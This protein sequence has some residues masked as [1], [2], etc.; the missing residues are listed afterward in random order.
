MKPWKAWK[1]NGNWSQ[2]PICIIRFQPAVAVRVLLQDH[3]KQN[4]N[5]CSQSWHYHLTSCSH[6]CYSLE[7]QDIA[8]HKSA[9]PT[10]LKHV[11]LEFW[12]CI[13]W[14]FI[15]RLIS[16][17]WYWCFDLDMFVLCSRSCSLFWVIFVVDVFLFFHFGC[18]VFSCSLSGGNWHRS[19][20]HS[21]ALSSLTVQLSVPPIIVLY[22]RH[23][24][25]V[26]YR[27]LPNRLKNVPLFLMFLRLLE[28]VDLLGLRG[29]PE[30][31]ISFFDSRLLVHVEK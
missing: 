26:P 23:I 25:P 2:N 5:P 8:E 7:I 10:L 18:S 30:K 12:C 17:L 13:F 27:Y 16:I 14:G 24:C 1:W 28:N 15:L 31:Q 20:C 11:S 6:V 29:S 3:L 19:S 9:T 4:L 21:C 22:D